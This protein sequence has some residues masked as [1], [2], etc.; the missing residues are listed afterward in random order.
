MTLTEHY[1]S[2]SQVDFPPGR[3]S[4]QSQWADPLETAFRRL[5]RLSPIDD[6][7]RELVL[8]SLGA[9]SDH[10][11]GADLGDDGDV[12]C[13]LRLSG[14]A[15]RISETPWGGRQIL[16]FILPGDSIGLSLRPRLDGLYRIVVLSRA[17][18]ID[19]R[20]LREQLRG[21]GPAYSNLRRACEQEER[22]TALRMVE[23]TSRLGGP[24]ATQAMAHLLLE[25]RG[26]LSEV[27]ELDGERFPM[28]LSQENLHHALGITVT[29]VYRV[30]TQMRKDGLIVLGSGWAEICNP[31]AL[32]AAAGLK[33]C[34]G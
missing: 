25:L 3:T 12:S 18:T 28:P 6:G 9:K 22:H 32:A 27:G 7:D 2:E 20:A 26:R 15:C 17:V 8:A 31:I 4:S 33:Q 19:A 11:V 1:F 21:N 10:R 34:R 5:D 14:W 30:L 24:S 29:Q 13:R 16:D 23:H